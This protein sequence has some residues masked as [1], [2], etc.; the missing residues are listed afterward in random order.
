MNVKNPFFFT[1]RELA[2]ESRV[3]L[4]SKEISAISRGAASDIVSALTKSDVNVEKE[5]LDEVNR[6]VAYAFSEE[7]YDKLL[8]KG[9]LSDYC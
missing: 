7:V 4:S 3:E 9:F 8:S 5:V 2:E 1:L 6:E